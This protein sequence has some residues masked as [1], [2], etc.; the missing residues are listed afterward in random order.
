MT[1]SRTE[2]LCRNQMNSVQPLGEPGQYC[3]R[4]WD[5]IMCWPETPAGQTVS[6]RC[7]TYFSAFTKD[8]FATKECTRDGTWYVSNVTNA[9]W[10]NY[11]DCLSNNTQEYGNIS[12]LIVRHIDYLTTMYNIGYALSMV[13]LLTAV[14]I[15]ISLRRL[16]CSRNTIH[17]HLFVSFI[18]RAATNLMKDTLLVQKLGFASDVESHADG[19]VAFRPDSSH[20][21]CKLFF[22][23]FFYTISANYS[24]IL[25]EGLY[26]HMVIYVPVFKETKVVRY[27]IFAGWITPLFS[28]VPWAVVRTT[29]ENTWCWNVHSERSHFWILKGYNVFTIVVNFVFFISIVR[30]LFSK[31][32]ATTQD[33]GKYRKLAKSTLVLIPLFGVHYIVFVCFPDKIKNTTVE[34]VKLYYEMFFNSFQGFVVALL[35]CFLNGEVRLE[36]AKVWQRY[37]L[38]KAFG[39]SPLNC[40]SYCDNEYIMQVSRR[41]SSRFSSRRRD[42]RSTS[43]SM[44][45]LAAVSSVRT[46]MQVIVSSNKNGALENAVI[47]L[48]P[49]NMNTKLLDAASSDQSTNSKQVNVRTS[50]QNDLLLTTLMQDDAESNES[51]AHRKSQQTIDG[52]L[53]VT[54]ENTTSRGIACTRGAHV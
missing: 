48:K 9:S 28:V 10:T 3:D 24:W 2:E 32:S 26:L 53:Y 21:E 33:V 11:T 12:T 44:M 31:I 34:L 46:A 30:I 50:S 19:T 54:I 41:E 4:T 35:F 14:I 13:S 18:L 43:T 27:L 6:M 36:L 52:D 40:C 47:R 23:I 45:P 37:K 5:G 29:L 7:A 8:G 22:T 38:G 42:P 1:L 25:V 15:L 49:T 16:S 17:L 39:G 51:P 20:W